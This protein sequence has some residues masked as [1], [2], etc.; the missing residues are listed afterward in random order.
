MSNA[1]H[2]VSNLDGLFCIFIAGT[3]RVK[4]DKELGFHAFTF[5]ERPLIYLFRPQVMTVKDS[6]GEGCSLRNSLPSDL[7]LAHL[8]CT[9]IHQTYRK[10]PQLAKGLNEIFSNYVSFFKNTCKAFCIF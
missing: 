1:Y 2:L 9:K 3:W 4:K 10:K 7:L 8:Q 6:K 5:N